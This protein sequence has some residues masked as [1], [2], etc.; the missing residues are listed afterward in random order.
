MKTAIVT[1]GAQVDIATSAIREAFG[2]I[3]VLVKAA[4]ADG[5]KK[6]LGMAFR[7]FCPT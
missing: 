5:F 4:G 7:L 1:G 6:F 3:L 2:P